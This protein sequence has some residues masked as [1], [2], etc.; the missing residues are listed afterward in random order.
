[1]TNKDVMYKLKREASRAHQMNDAHI[2][3]PSQS[4]QRYGRQIPHTIGRGDLDETFVSDVA[5]P[6]AS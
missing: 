1:M 6:A 3:D 2:G 4:P 5:P